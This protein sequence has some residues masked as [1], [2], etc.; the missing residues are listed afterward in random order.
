MKKATLIAVGAFAV[1]L[2]L[3]LATRERQVSVGVRKLAPSGLDVARV[4]RV[5]LTG[6]HNATLLKEGDAWTV[7]DPSRPETRYA[8]NAARVQ[9]ALE[10]LARLSGA[11]FVT[12][13]AE[14]LAEYEL[15]DAKGLKVRLHQEGGAPLELVLG[16]DGARNGG[17][18]V[19]EASGSLV[20]AHPAWLGGAW[21]KRVEDWRERRLVRAEASDIT[22][23]TVRIGDAAPLTLK[24]GG[25]TE[26]WK[27]A[28]GTQAPEG[29]LFGAQEA[30]RLARSV[31]S[32]QAQD[33]LEGDAAAEAEKALAAG[34]DTVEARLK[35][36]KSVVV[37]LERPSKPEQQ[38]PVA[39]RIEGDAQVYRVSGVAAA[40]LRKRLA[41]FRER[42]LM[43]FEPEKVTRIKVQA[44]RDSPV[45]VA[46]EAQ[47]W[48]LVEP[49]KLPDGVR[50]DAAMVDSML[51][52]L[53]GIEATRVIEPSVPDKAAGLA[54]PTALVELSLDGAPAQTLRLGKEAPSDST[55]QKE[56]YAR[57][58]LDALTYA[59][60]EGPTLDFL[61][62]GVGLFTRSAQ[63]GGLGA[64]ALQGLESLPP[65]VRRQLEAQL[66]AA[67]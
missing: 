23:L 44:G 13:R 14:R 57:T 42:R 59:V 31:A 25:S 24:G 6:T 61:S 17:T 64:G 27:L 15:D 29:F 12:D 16:K 34:H 9:S 7:A 11:D 4:T 20:F 33:F 51:M 1:L 55:A 39:V 26:G 65:E 21:R 10:S 41:D 63:A 35:D 32:L 49:K 30:E 66:G 22:E 5:E 54:S 37:K 45:V 46:R 52:R 56:R 43:R 67:R 36:G 8:A 18:Y 48:T 58:S 2:V 47:G 3:V 60:A 28:E 38:D 62:R 50:F 53:R 40:A 19:R